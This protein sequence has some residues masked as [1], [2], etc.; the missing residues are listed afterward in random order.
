MFCFS[1]AL[2]IGDISEIQPGEKRKQLLSSLYHIYPENLEETVSALIKKCKTNLE[3]IWTCSAQGEPMRIWYSAQPDELCEMYWFMDQVRRMETHGEV[4]V[5]QLPEWE[6]RNNGETIHR[7][8]WGEL[9]PGQWGGYIPLQRKVPE[10][11]ISGCASYWE[12][13]QAENAPL[14]GMLNGLLVSMPADLYDSFIIR[15]IELEEDEFIEAKLIG[16]LL[17]KYHEEFHLIH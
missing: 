12:R 9:D 15:E 11:F 16:K 14:R 17:G 3:N 13:L 10:S 8:G 7:S 2:S 4:Y 6:E 5:V 1:L